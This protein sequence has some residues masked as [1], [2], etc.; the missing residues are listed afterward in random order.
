MKREYYLLG[1]LV[2]ITATAVTNFWEIGM[3]G[4]TVFFLAYLTKG[5][6]KVDLKKVH[7][8]SQKFT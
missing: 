7:K 3:M 5:S 6:R 4:L 2:I 1:L 8:N